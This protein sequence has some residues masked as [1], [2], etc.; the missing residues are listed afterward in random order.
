VALVS[1]LHGQS[2]TC[3][4]SATESHAILS[5]VLLPPCQPSFTSGSIPV[6]ILLVSNPMS[7]D[8]TR[9][10]PRVSGR[11]PLKTPS[12]S[13]NT[14]YAFSVAYTL[15]LYH[16]T[17]TKMSLHPVSAAR[18]T[19]LTRR[20]PCPAA[21]RAQIASCSPRG[22]LQVYASKSI[23]L[24]FYI[25]Q[26]PLNEQSAGVRRIRCPASARTNAPLRAA[27]ALCAWGAVSKTA[28]AAWQ[29]R[30]PP[31]GPG[32]GSGSLILSS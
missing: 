32:L 3:I 31:R 12:N 21:H 26:T 27:T 15:A 23:I 1:T 14:T 16:I 29:T 24:V 5:L 7:V 2:M 19:V 10:K 28:A 9:V 22:S 25:H 18:H 20:C 6:P 30:R 8:Q 4:A 11:K 17:F 13:E